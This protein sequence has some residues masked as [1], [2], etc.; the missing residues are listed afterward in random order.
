MYKEIVE[1]LLAYPQRGQIQIDFDLKKKIFKLTVPI[2]SSK[3][4]P[5]K[6]KDYAMARKNFTFKPH[7]T[8]YHVEGEKV[9]LLQEIPFQL[10]FQ[11][12][13]RSEVDQ[14]WQ[15]SKYCHKL[16]SEIAIEDTYK[17]ALRI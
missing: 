9:F 12:T 10:D 4:L 3:R 8:S 5:A 1:R 17:N 14:F 16:L 13:S 2:F 15:L 6:I 7:M 11:S